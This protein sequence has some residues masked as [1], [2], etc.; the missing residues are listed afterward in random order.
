MLSPQ[1]LPPKERP[2][3]I[4]GYLLMLSEVTS[5]D[6][7]AMELR[8]IGNGLL[9]IRSASPTRSNVPLPQTRART[10]RGALVESGI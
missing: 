5:L 6:D 4:G 10:A 2:R 8:S 1:P 7:V 9:G 3:E